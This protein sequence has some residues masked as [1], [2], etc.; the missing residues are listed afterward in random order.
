MDKYSHRT[1]SLHRGCRKW[2][3]AT[4][5]AWD[6]ALVE[7]GEAESSGTRDFETWKKGAMG[8][9]FHYFH[10]IGDGNQ[11]D[12][13]GFINIQKKKRSPIKGGMTTAHIIQYIKKNIFQ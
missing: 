6:F 11:P 3:C 8:L 9:N 7:N 2:S 12:S 1:A 13:R 5:S 10:M 4:E